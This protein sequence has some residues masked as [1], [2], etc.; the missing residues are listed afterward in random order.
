[1]SHAVVA[2][3]VNKRHPGFALS[4]F[5]LQVDSGCITGIFGPTGAGKTTLLK[6]FAGITRPDSGELTVLGMSY[7]D[8]EREIKD[9]IGFV[10]EEPHLYPDKSLEWIGSFLR[11]VYS[12]WDP[13]RFSDLMRRFRIDSRKKI[14]ELSRGQ[15]ALALLAAALSHDPDVIVLDQPLSGLDLLVRRGVLALFRELV[16][17]EEKTI[18]LASHITDGLVGLVDHVAFMSAGRLILYEEKDVLMSKWKWLRFREDGLPAEVLETLSLVEDTGFGMSGLTN[19]FDD[20]SE[21]LARPIASGDLSV[22]GAT[23]DDVLV[24]LLKGG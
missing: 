16:T 3:N 13:T 1:M 18:V 17:D 22:D 12:S 23:L 19:Q 20:I 9:R 15:R 4:D 21:Q 10:S 24:A 14:R 6:I 5:S 11:S 2:R 7:S 8:R